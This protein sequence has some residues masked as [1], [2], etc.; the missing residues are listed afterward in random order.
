MNTEQS[1]DLSDICIICMSIRITN[2]CYS[3]F[4]SQHSKYDRVII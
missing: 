2:N 4:D 1:A 3:K